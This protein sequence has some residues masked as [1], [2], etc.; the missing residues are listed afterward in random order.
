MSMNCDNCGGNL[1][2]IES[3][4]GVTEGSFTEEYQCQI[5]NLTM[6]IAGEADAPPETWQKYGAAYGGES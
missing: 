4:G 5:C 2:L 1:E 6:T 3:N